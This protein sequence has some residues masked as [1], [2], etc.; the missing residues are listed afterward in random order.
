MGRNNPE[1]LSQASATIPGRLGRF[2]CC[3]CIAQ[4]NR[5]MI[6]WLRVYLNGHGIQLV[7]DLCRYTSLQVCVAESMTPA[8][9]HKLSQAHNSTAA[10]HCITGTLLQI[11]ETLS[12]IPL[13][14]LMWRAYATC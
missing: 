7:A 13:Q 3:P 5:N 10:C 12:A 6:G 11:T 4:Q 9:A 1:V 14:M 2:R 8:D